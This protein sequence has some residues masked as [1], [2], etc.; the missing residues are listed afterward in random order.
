MTP[1]RLTEEE[2]RDRLQEAHRRCHR[3][4]ANGEDPHPDRYWESKGRWHVWRR[5]LN[6]L[7]L[8]KREERQADAKRARKTLQ[9]AVAVLKAQ[10]RPKYRSSDP[11]T[12][13]RA[14]LEGLDRRPTQAARVL[15]R[16]VRMGPSTTDAVVRSLEGIPLNSGSTRVSELKAYGFLEP[17]G[18]TRETRAGSQAE[19]LR[20]TVEIAEQE[21]LRL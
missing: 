16:F 9:E 3:F 20:A 4:A 6:R 19:V 13:K 15:A 17:T 11:E 1:L 18:E 10:N 8:E 12:S 21:E 7:E 2:V 14:A 5:L